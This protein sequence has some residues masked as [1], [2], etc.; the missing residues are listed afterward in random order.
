M[1]AE[2]VRIERGIFVLRLD[3]S[4]YDL[5]RGELV[6]ADAPAKDLVAAVRVIARGEALLSPS[7]T[8]RLIEEFARRHGDFAIIGIAA[9]IVRDGARCTMARLATAG[10]GPVPMRLRNAPTRLMKKLGYGKGYRYAHDEEG[11]FAAGEHYFP[12]NMAQVSWYEPTDR[13]LE[14]KI[15]EKLEW[16]RAQDRKARGDEQ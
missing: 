2:T 9:M 3:I 15:R 5:D 11:A 10:A 6:S 14:A 16:L 7:V 8:K 13:G 1:R 4:E 12:D